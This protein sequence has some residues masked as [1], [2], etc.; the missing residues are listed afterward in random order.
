MA[1]GFGAGVLWGLGV[2]VLGLVTLSQLAPP[3]ASVI[4]AQEKA[5]AEQKAAEEVAEKAAAEANAA[6]EKAAAE[7]AAAEAKAAEEKAAAEKVAAEAKA[8]EEKAAAEKAAAEARAAE[9]RAAA[10]AAANLAE[11]HKLDTEAPPASEAAA[12][13]EASPPVVPAEGPKAPVAVAELPAPAAPEGGEDM[14]SLTGLDQ[15]LT[16]PEAEPAP[17]PVEAAPEA[18]G[19]VLLQPGQPE[20]QAE[21]ERLPEIA[22]AAE[23]ETQPAAVPEVAEPA[24]EAAPEPDQQATL[25]DDQP[26]LPGAAPLEDKLPT[27]VMDKEVPGVKVGE[28]PQVEAEP[29]AP[30]PEAQPAPEDLPPFRRYAREFQPEGKPLFAI[31]LRDVGA[32]GMSRAE[33]ASLPFPV[34]IVIDPLDPGAKAAMADW[35]AAGQEVVT[36]ANG[37]PEGATAGDIETTFATLEAILPEAVAVIDQDLGGFQDDRPLATLVLPVIEGQGRGILTYDRGLNAADQIARR[38][39]VPSATIFRRLDA[40]GES[41]QTIRRYLDRAAFKAAQEGAVV[42]IGDTRPETVAAILEWT[43]E[44]KAGTVSLA[45]ITAV[46]GR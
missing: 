37:I 25:K 45:P 46:M 38:V 16:A 30:A 9:E 33:L 29:A 1:R 13:P 31:L 27:T 4:A 43:V 5:A 22:P 32:A 36:L 18:P 10:E 44:G 35:R 12:A 40:E 2:A 24:P 20:G 8:A 21:P 3:P 41:R 11:Q 28:L 17:A 39:G 34:S 7:K 15:A 19:D 23:P 42:V 26:T 6:E 14:P